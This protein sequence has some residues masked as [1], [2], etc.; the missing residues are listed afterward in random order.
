VYANAG[1]GIHLWHDVHNVDI[2]NNTSFGNGDGFIVGG[3]DYVHTSGPADYITVTNNIAFDN[4]GLGFDEEG[5][6]GSHNLFTNNLS[7]K[8]GQ[9]WRLQTSGHSNDVTADPQ[10]VN[11]LRKGGGDYHLKSTSPAI[12]QGIPA[13]AP[14]TDFD[15]VARPRGGAFDLGAYEY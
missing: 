12:N 11:Y 6:D 1:G 8:N 2:A 5:Q 3:G 9:D 13:Y 4:V 7:F 15:G 10:F 14:S